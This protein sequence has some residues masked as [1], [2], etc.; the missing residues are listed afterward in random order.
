[1]LLRSYVDPLMTAIDL[2]FHALLT[3]VFFQSGGV[4]STLVTFVHR[5]FFYMVFVVQDFAVY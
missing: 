3:C 2:D 1:M 4:S 5:Q